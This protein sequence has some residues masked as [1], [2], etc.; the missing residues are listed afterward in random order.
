M[1]NLLEAHFELLVVNAQ[2][3][4]AVPGRKTDIK[5]AEWIADLLQ[6][7]LLRASFIPSRQQREVR[8]LTR[9]R[10]SVIEER[11]RTINRL[12]KT[13]EDANI[14]LASVATDIMG[15]SAHDMLTALLQGETDTVALAQ[16]ARGNMRPKLELLEQALQGR[17]TDQHRFLLSKQLTHIDT[18]DQ[19][20]EQ[21]GVEIAKRLHPFE[22]ILQRLETIPGIK[23][24]L[25]EVILSEVGVDMSRFPSARHLASWAGMCPGNCESAGKRLSGRTRKGSSWL[26]CAL[27]EA[28]HA[29]SR[30]KD[31]YLSA[32]YQRLARRRGGKKATVAVGHSLLVIA[33]HVVGEGKEYEELGGNYFDEWDRQAVQ[34]RLVRRL[35]KL[36]YEVTLARSSPVV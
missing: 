2:H 21:L 1:Y 26:R 14:K 32:Q 15:A 28:A 17:L 36:G 9:Y 25:A 29:A 30:C 11:G 34:K 4:K 35:E 33:Y 20:I 19:E 13:L 6:H 23:R 5:D 16:L 12:Q 8:E 24:R 18:L 7:G 3:I 31:C 10:T 27:V 22:D